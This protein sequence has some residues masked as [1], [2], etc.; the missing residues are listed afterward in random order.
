M[1]Y[2]D[3]LLRRLF[4]AT[5]D[6]LWL[7]GL[8]GRTLMGNRRFA[9]LTG[10]PLE[11]LTSVTGFMLAD[12]QGRADFAAHLELMRSGHHGVDNEDVL[13][14]RRDGTQIW[15]LASWAPVPD[16]DGT[17]VIGYLH[18]MTEQTERRRLLDELQDREVQLATA[19]RIAKLG[20][21]TWDLATD[22]VW[23]SPELYEIYGVS[24]DEFTCDYAG[25]V[26]LI[27]PDD[28]AGFGASVLSAINQ[29]DRFE[30]E[31]RTITPS[32][33]LRW[34]R[35]VGEVERDDDGTVVRLSGTGQDV[36]ERRLALDAA[37]TATQRLFLLQQLAEAA[38]RSTTLADALVRS[39]QLLD[40]ES[41]WVPLCAVTRAERG[42]PLSALE[43][44]EPVAADLPPPDL[45]AAAE[46]W[47][48]RE[49]VLTALPGRPGSTL[50]SLPVMAGRSMAL[51]VQV[52]DETS[53]DPDDDFAWSLMDQVSAQLS[54]VAERERAAE[55]LAEARDQ[56][57]DASR[58][59]SDF[60][61]TMS[62]EIRTP[63]NGVIGLTDLLLRT[64]L[65]DRQQRLA[66]GL[67]GAGLTLL[68]LINDILDL[69][70]IESGKLELEAIDFDVRHVV[71][72]TATILAGPAVD[73]GLELVVGCAPEV[74]RL[75]RGDPVRLGQVLTNLGSN[76]VKFT[77]AGEVV[78]D[79][80]L[81]PD[82]PGGAEDGTVLLRVEVR[83][84]GIGI[85]L[86]E[87]AA[88]LFEAFTQ[89]D[90]S[91][92]RQHGGTGLG[93]AIS[94]Q[95][96]EGMGGEIGVHSTP[97]AGSTFWFTARLGAVDADAPADDGGLP[98]DTV[99]RRADTDGP[100]LPRR[101]VL[102]AAD[103]PST[104]A[105]LVRQLAAWQL[106]V[107]QVGSADAA[108][109]ALT[110]AAAAGTPYDV[111]LVDLTP[112]G[113]VS[114]ELGQ[115][116]R[117]EPGL[118]ALQLVLVAGEG[119]MTDVELAAAGY[120]A[121]VTKPV[122]TSELHPALFGA[123]GRGTVA[124]APDHPRPADR[125]SLG[126]RVLVVEDNAVNQ[127]VATGLL[128]SLGCTVVAVGNGL[129]AVDALGEGHGFDVVLMDC[130]MPRMD[131]FDATRAIR[132]RE[133]GTRVPIIAMT[134]SATEGERQRCLEAGMDDFLTKPVDPTQLA[135]AVA[136]APRGARDTPSLVVESSRP[137]VA[138]GALD[139]E[140]VALLSELVKDGV[141]FFA[142]TRTSFLA[143]IDGALAQ[144][145][146]AV[147]D[148][149][150][151]RSVADAHQLRGSALNLGL[152]RVGAA[153]GAIEE[154]ARTGDL[155]GADELVAVLREAVTEGVEALVAVD[156]P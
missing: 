7:I 118:A 57:M 20:S 34:I 117:A 6:A 51:V 152:T 55:A 58:H 133:R 106:D 110:D 49:K 156:A 102:V 104:T 103:H 142:R 82:G 129:E 140:R 56:A 73:K 70:K 64:D 37:T 107:G 13:L 146:I 19:Q 26:A 27:H 10:Y 75:V 2:D 93:L 143:R 40:A 41:G 91:T 48:T 139:P 89:A 127:L 122:R 90:R 99:G 148:G 76:A 100:P 38:N 132:A 144:I 3:T 74:P 105:F 31:G 85:D 68:A 108:F 24:R 131:G 30:S 35:G 88:G 9:E 115:R 22:V 43:L 59:K 39:A 119:A 111:A 124:S 97:G 126:L 112:T 114:L 62:H 137:F 123:G 47:R 1:A 80:H 42:G 84:T 5:P 135:A 12:E 120:Q 14:V 109:T 125:P 32:G 67:R 36:T 11:D 86:G 87:D 153:A 101:R 54:S 130:R 4:D 71:D 79:V 66:E 44:P 21:W 25:F 145:S 33:E 52:I 113:V 65:D 78:I 77:E 149:D 134:A 53:T 95:L 147:A 28:R 136:R 45:E 141:S 8:D 121:R 151:E 46:C 155:S 96:A 63:M 150:L 116:L 81:A 15:T 94:R 60:L 154:L 61:A 92:T 23:W 18:R 83:D 50:L 138:E 69:S 128:E 72:E 16:A 98:A 29:Q 17:G